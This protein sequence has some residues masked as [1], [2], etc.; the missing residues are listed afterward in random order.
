METR[1]LKQTEQE[2]RE[3]VVRQLEWDPRVNAK[4]IAVTVAGNVVTLTGSVHNYAERCAAEKAVQVVY[5]VEAVAN[6]IEVRPPAAR[7]DAEIAQ[8]ILHAMKINVTVPHDKIKVLVSDGVATLD[9]TVDWDYQRK[10]AEA[11]A[12]NA[13]GVKRVHNQ[14]NLRIRVSPTEV[15]DK[16]A[17]ALRRHAELDA[18]RIAVY[19]AD[20]KVH[21]YGSVGSWA[22]REAAEGA[23]W[24]APGVLDVIDHLSV[25]R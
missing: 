22:E 14:I 18:R 12:R 9:G 5:G 15:S 2:L 8:D 6:D 21:L 24:A 4:N 19:A 23:A 1:T 20:G 13:A 7:V 3:E 16:I 10:N 11:C 17:E 25:V